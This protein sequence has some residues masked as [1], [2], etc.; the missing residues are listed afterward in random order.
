M[1]DP[2]LTLRPAHTGDIP[3]IARLATMLARQ[4]AAY[5][6]QRFEFPEPAE[7]AFEAFFEQQ[8]SSPR[9]VVTVA[10]LEGA[11]A[12]YVFLRMEPESLPH[13]CSASVWIHDIYVD[14]CARGAGAG[15][16]LMDSALA[17][18]KAMGSGSVMLEVS[19][20]NRRASDIFTA[21]GFRP[22]MV[23]MRLEL[24]NA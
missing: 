13:L 4:H 23:E 24:P 19:T 14:A 9:A 20:A 16:A 17:S 22:T 1:P 21:A 6:A 18:A 15:K 11:I 10:E 7:A 12:G 8:L 3:V 5:D 2:K